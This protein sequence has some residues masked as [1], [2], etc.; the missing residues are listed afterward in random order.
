[1]KIYKIKNSKGFYSEGGIN[2]IWSCN[3][4]VWK[5]LG[6][7]KLHLNAIMDDWNYIP[8]DWQVVECIITENE[9][10][11]CKSLYEQQYKDRK[12]KEDK[13]SRI[14]KLKHINDELTRLEKLKEALD[15]IR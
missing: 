5:T 13:K 9:S 6:H 8:D 12:S 15:G 1:M 2:N 4:K 11:S 7:V 10:Q 3:G 14:Y